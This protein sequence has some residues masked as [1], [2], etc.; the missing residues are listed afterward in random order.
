MISEAERFNINH[1]N[2]CSH[3]KWKGQFIP[4]EPDP[5]AVPSHDGFFWCLFTQT[6]IGPD[7]ELAEPAL[8]S[9]SGRACHG[10]GWV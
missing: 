8:C 5:N 4:V 2:L 1:P 9:S 6:C 7:G 10:K 3:L